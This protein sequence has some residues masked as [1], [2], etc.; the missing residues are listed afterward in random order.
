MRSNIK[1]TK[2]KEKT[3]KKNKSTEENVLDIDDISFTSDDKPPKL[4]H[5]SKFADMH[6]TNAKEDEVRGEI[7]GLPEVES[8]VSLIEFLLQNN[9]N[10]T[11]VQKTKLNDFL[12]QDFKFDDVTK[13]RKYVDS[14]IQN[15]N[16]SIKPNPL[17][18]NDGII[19]EAKDVLSFIL[20][21]Y[22]NRFGV[23]SDVQKEILRK[24]RT[25]ILKR[26]VNITE[27]E[28]ISIQNHIR[29]VIYKEKNEIMTKIDDMILSYRKNIQK[30]KILK[31]LK[32]EL[33]LLVDNYLSKADSVYFTEQLKLLQT[34]KYI[35]RENLLELIDD[36]LLKIKI[37]T[38][39]DSSMDKINKLKT[40]IRGKPFILP[41]KY[42]NKIMNKLKRIIRGNK[43]FIF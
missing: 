39:P 32:N 14:I 28:L 4:K 19:N 8:L 11:D 7:E 6:E 5:K 12:L 30:Q 17:I 16:R 1:K 37:D 3:Q 38:Y 34:G 25:Y 43:F 35:I 26:D 20:H 36:E 23:L 9:D 2:T 18:L 15:T 41:H 42:K 21:I 22:R 10:L 33:K 40:K 13:M 31:E 24:Y 29:S 27:N